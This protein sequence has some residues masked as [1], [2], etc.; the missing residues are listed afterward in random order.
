MGGGG[1]R[2][3][4]SMASKY[5]NPNFLARVS[6]FVCRNLSDAYSEHRL[7]YIYNE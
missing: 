4:L 3:V 7:A 2:V 6:N 5:S 1:G